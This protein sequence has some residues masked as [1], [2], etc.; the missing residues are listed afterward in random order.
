MLEAC[1]LEDSRFEREFRVTGLQ[2]KKNLV[3]F[4]DKDSVTPIN[5]IL[6]TDAILQERR[7]EQKG[8]TLQFS[9]FPQ[10]IFVK[11]GIF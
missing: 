1:I 9:A 8:H 5:K 3:W 6:K 4:S 11:E 10:F 7:Y 2:Q